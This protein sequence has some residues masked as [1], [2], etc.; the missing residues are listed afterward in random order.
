V[1]FTEV[2]AIVTDT[3]LG[4]EDRL[5]VVEAGVELIETASEAAPLP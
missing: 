3:H 1:P 2:D 5:A 4:E